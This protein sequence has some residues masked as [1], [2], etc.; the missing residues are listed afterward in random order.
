[1]CISNIAT[2]LGDK[3]GEQSCV[4]PINFFDDLFAKYPD[5]RALAIKTY[6]RQKPARKVIRK[7][8]RNHFVGL[9]ASRI[10]QALVPF[11]SNLERDACSLFESFSEI[12]SYRSQPYR[13][14][15]WYADGIR[16]VYPDFEVTKHSGEILVVDVKR[17]HSAKSSR[18]LQRI[19]ELSFHCHQRGMGYFLLTEEEIRG[20]RIKNARWL[21]SLC[22]GCAHQ[23]VVDSLWQWLDSLE[24][25]TLG[26]VFQNIA[27][28]PSVRTAL[29]ELILDG[30]IAVD[31]EN[32]LLNQTVIP[33]TQDK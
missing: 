7:G 9:F 10:N 25:L 21:L 32:E 17:S 27:G 23:R 26:E 16:N 22:H 24:P 13:I 31:W 5:C 29:A 18:F 20:N 4:K 28:Y 12:Q 1:M 14:R 2:L 6:E 15:L 30:H 33:I 19:N 11:E 8:D 3:T